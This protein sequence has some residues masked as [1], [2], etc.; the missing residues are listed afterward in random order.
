[1]HSKD[2]DNTKVGNHPLTNIISKPENM[3]R[4]IHNIEN[5]SE[6][7]KITSQ[8]NSVCIYLVKSKS[9]GNHKPKNYNGTHMEKKKKK[10]SKCSTKDS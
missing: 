2:E 3:R 6:N 4:Q 10:K 1:M 5:A 8:N 9:D 7:K